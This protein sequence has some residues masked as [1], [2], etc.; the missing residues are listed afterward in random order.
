[1]KKVMRTWVPVVM[2]V[3]LLTALVACGGGGGKM[4]A[5]VAGFLNK[6]AAITSEGTA[7]LEAAKGSPEDAVKAMNKV[8]KKL[9]K[10]AD[11]K[12]ALMKKYPNAKSD[13]SGLEKSKVFM[14]A[15]KNAR[16]GR[17]ALRRAARDLRDKFKDNDDV[18]KTYRKLRKWMRKAN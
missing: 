8:V 7:K 15:E 5:D 11:E 3:T 6:Q 2:A 16:K 13:D 14:Q 12:K 10:L 1:M 9:V 17:R 18:K 4:A